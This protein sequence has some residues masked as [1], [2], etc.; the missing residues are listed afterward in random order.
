MPYLNA[1]QKAAL[2]VELAKPEYQNL[3]A[4]EAAKILNTPSASVETIQKPK[5]FTRQDILGKLSYA[6]RRKVMTLAIATKIIDAINAVD[7]QAI[8]EYADSLRGDPNGPDDGEITQAE[9]TAI[10]GVLVATEPHNRTTYGQTPFQTLFGSARF[11]VK[12]GDGNLAINTVTSG[13]CL[14][15]M[16][17]EALS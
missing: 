5:P 15:E 10:V 6:S 9:F 1:E 14:P 4:S 7:R 8:G 12:D 2:A 13:T 16:V 3:S 11:E 17:Q